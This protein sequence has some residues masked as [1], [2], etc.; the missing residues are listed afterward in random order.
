LADTSKYWYTFQLLVLKVGT[1]VESELMS[2]CGDASSFASCVVRITM[3]CTWGPA[4]ITQDI[5]A[6][7]IQLNT[8]G[9]ANALEDI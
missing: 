7:G 5:K 4:Q 9:L 6:G 3:I 1:S 2:I 8:Q